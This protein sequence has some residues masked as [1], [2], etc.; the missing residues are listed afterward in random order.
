MSFFA[1]AYELLAHREAG[2]PYAALAR[3]A[4]WQEKSVR[5]IVSRARTGKLRE[6]GQPRRDAWSS[7]MDAVLTAYW[8]TENSHRIAGRLSLLRPS[9]THWAVN[10]RARRLHLVKPGARSDWWSRREGL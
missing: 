2:L 4:G 10:A 7:E 1:T 6:P 5:S 8:E 9:I 3:L